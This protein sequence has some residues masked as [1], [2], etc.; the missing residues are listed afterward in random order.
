MSSEEKI[1]VLQGTLYLIVLRTLQSMG[2]QH[3]YALALTFCVR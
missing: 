3:A 2:P 1:A